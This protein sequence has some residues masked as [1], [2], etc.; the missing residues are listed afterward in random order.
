[1]PLTKNLVQSSLKMPLKRLSFWDNSWLL[2]PYGCP[3]FIFVGEA[4]PGVR[5]VTL[6]SLFMGV[7]YLAR[8]PVTLSRVTG[9]GAGGKGGLDGTLI[10]FICTAYTSKGN[11]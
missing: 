11:A 9:T 3:E 4:G 1:M 7:L 8:C 6:Q 2:T 10:L 5:T